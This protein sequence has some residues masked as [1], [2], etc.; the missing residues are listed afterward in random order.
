MRA[1][2]FGCGDG[3]RICSWSGRPWVS[4]IV[5]VI[6]GDDD[7]AIGAHLGGRAAENLIFFFFFILV[8]SFQI[9]LNSFFKF[10][11]NFNILNYFKFN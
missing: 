9:L 7:V 4:G 10:L 5:A 2:G 6:A 3:A 11:F 1:G 8:F